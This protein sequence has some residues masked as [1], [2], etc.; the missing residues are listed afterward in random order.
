MGSEQ[1]AVIGTGNDP[2]IIDPVL[3]EPERLGGLM[4]VLGT[5]DYEDRRAMAQHLLNGRPVK[6]KSLDGIVTYIA[7]RTEG[8]SQRMIADVVNRLVPINAQRRVGGSPKSGDYAGIVETLDFGTIDNALEYAMRFYQ[9]GHL[10]ENMA[11]I[12]KFFDELGVKSDGAG[13]LAGVNGNRVPSLPK[14][15][16]R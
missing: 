5:P 12:R 16:A 13:F 7:E 14:R 10:K 1:P 3:R 6:G 9:F 4:M 8:F 15:A 2:Y 11:A